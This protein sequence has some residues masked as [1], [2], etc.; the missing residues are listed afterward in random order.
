MTQFKRRLRALAA[1]VAMLAVGLQP[2]LAQA[3]AARQIVIRDTEVE[4]LMREYASPILAAAGQ[5][6]GAVQIILIGERSFNAFVANGRRIFLNTGALIDSKTPNEII[7]VIAHEAGHIAGGHLTRL[8]EE[9]ANA[10]ILAVAGMLLGAGAV[11]GAAAGGGGVGN[12]GQGAM[13]VFGGSQELVRRNLLAYQR[14]EEQAADRAALNYLSATKQSPKGMLTTFKRFADTGLFASRAVDPYQVSHP[15]PQDRISN[16]EETARKSPQFDALD[17]APMQAR[18]D[19][20]RAK[21][22]GFMERPDTVARSFPPGDASLAARYARAISTYK[23]GR[24]PEALSLID[25]LVREQPG[26]PYFWELK[27]QALLESG[28]AREAVAP[29]RKAVAMAP[30]AALIRILLGHALVATEDP[31]NMDEAV[32]ELSGAA[33][34]DPDAPEA[35]RHLAD[36]YARK[37]DLGMA[38]LSTARYYLGIGNFREAHNQAA[39]A[40]TK[41][42]QG[43]PGWVKAEDILALRPPGST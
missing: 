7:G 1:S 18:H 4:A 41:L 12:A 22:I 36:A 33:T 27:G 13:G 30:S 20:M 16:L 40:Q 23:N 32:R 11:A 5:R 34:R 37:G 17:P 15:L 31:R 29:L 9:I 19:L 3:P 39:R 6:A 26:N 42:P 21:L 38:E 8:R 35:Y 43:S 28:Q 2:V 14:S 24:L 10:Q 25:G